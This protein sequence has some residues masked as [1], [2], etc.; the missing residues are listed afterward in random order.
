VTNA[1]GNIVAQYVDNIRTKLQTEINTNVENALMHNIPDMYVDNV[2]NPTK[3]ILIGAGIFAIAN[4]KKVNGDWD[5]RTIATGDKVIADEVAASWVY[6]GNIIADQIST[7]IPD[8]KISSASTWNNKINE[9]DAVTIIGNTVTAPYVNALSIEAATV[10]SDWLYA[11]DI[12]A[13]QIKSGSISA[14]RISGGT[15]SGVTIAVT[16]D[17]LVG[18]K[19]QIGGGSSKN[20]EIILYQLGEDYTKL[21]TDNVGAFN[22]ENFKN[23]Y[24]TSAETLRLTGWDDLTMLCLDGNVSIG[25]GANNINL[26][27]S[28]LVLNGDELHPV[29]VKN[30]APTDLSS[31]WI[32]TSGI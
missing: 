3:A 32:D 2:E 30:T 27:C 5:W 6:A 23:I 1:K 11:G 22:I 15:L 18:N 26:D 14:D 28:H 8:S 21:Y 19:L 25:A 17:A 7:S 10:K 24:L 13:N 20:K 31:V 29:V 4:S 9:N 12:N 16:T